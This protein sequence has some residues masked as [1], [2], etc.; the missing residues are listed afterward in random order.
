MLD[1]LKPSHRIL[2]RALF[3]FWGLT[4]IGMLGTVEPWIVLSYAK[5]TIVEGP[6]QPWYERV[7]N[8]FSPVLVLFIGFLAGFVA[9]AYLSMKHR[10]RPM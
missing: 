6:T 9:C 2:T 3:S 8:I 10:Y 7:L 5:V 4:A 1:H